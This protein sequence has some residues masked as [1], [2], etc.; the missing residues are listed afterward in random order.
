MCSISRTCTWT[1]QI[2]DLRDVDAQEF[3]HFHAEAAERMIEFVQKPGMIWGLLSDHKKMGEFFRLKVVV[4]SVYVLFAARLCLSCSSCSCAL[5]VS[6]GDSRFFFGVG[7]VKP[8]SI[9]LSV[10]AMLV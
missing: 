6:F 2:L 1:T 4:A 3:P 9:P 5:L 8:W 10:G 7:F